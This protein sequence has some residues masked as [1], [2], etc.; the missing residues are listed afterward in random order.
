MIYEVKPLPRPVDCKIEV[1]GSKSI[2]NRALLLASMAQGESVLTNVLFSDDSRSCMDCLAALGYD[3]NIDE[4]DKTVRLTGGAPAEKARINVRSAGTSARFLTALLAASKGEYI[5]DSSEQMKRRPMKPLLDAL[6]GLGCGIEYMEKEGFLPYKIYGGALSGGEVA[7]EAEQSSQ[8]TSALL[9]TGC[10]HRNGLIIRTTGRET[11]KSYIG[12]T[13]KMMEQFGVSVKRPAEGIYTVESGQAYSPREYR[14]EPD[15]SS[16]CY[17][18]AAAALSGGSTLVKDARFS[19][20]Q[21]DVKFL[22]ILTELGCAAKE[23]GEGILLKGPEQGIYKGID[24]DMNDCSDQAITLAVLAPFA[25]SPTTIRNIGHIKHQESNRVRAVLTELSKMGIRCVET[26]DGIRIWPGTPKPS[27]VETYDDHRV[28]M[29]FS[30][31]GLRAEGI[32]IA[33][34]SCVAK[35]FENYFET[36]EELYL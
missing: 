11:A 20:M 10:L 31:I 17:F 13:L 5:I 7:V 32:R 36:L 9:M 4:A 28:A 22:D 29:A 12:I 8:F 34:P 33:N 1:P 27:L 30:L 24:V 2:T 25:S 16:A 18:Y 21:G 35:T 19:S 14:I 15:I 3:I 23:I 26:D 6:A